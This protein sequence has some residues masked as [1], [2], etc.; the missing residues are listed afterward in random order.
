MRVRKL[1]A[2]LALAFLPAVA[3]AQGMGAQDRGAEN[4]AGPPEFDDARY[5]EDYSF[6]RDPAN[7][8]GAWWERYK[9]IPLD[10]TGTHYLTLGADLRL[11]YEHY[12]NRD[13]GEAPAP[14]DGYGLFRVMPYADLH[15]GSHFRLF[16][17]LIGAWSVDVDP[18]PTPVDETGL[19]VLQAFAQL[20]FARNSRTA[21][22][23]GGRQ[24][25]SYGSE[26]LI[27]MRFGEN[28][29]LAFDGGLARIEDGDWRVDA[30]F[31]Q[32]VENRRDS[33]DDK[34]DS[35]RKLWS[36]YATR[37]L[38]YIG[39][40]SGLDLYYIGFEDEK[41]SYEQGTGEETRHTIGSRFFGTLDNWT[42]DWEGFLQFGSF[43]D[44]DILAWAVGGVTRYTFTDLRLK[45]FIELR[46]NAI[47]GDRDPDD[48]ELNS[49]NA[50]F[51]RAKYFGEIGVLGPRNL[52]N[53]HPIAGVDLG[54]GWSL[55]GATVFFWRE[56]LDDGV[57][58]GPGDLLRASGDS[59]ARYIGTQSELVLGWSAARGVDIQA[60]YSVFKPGSFIEETG[61][62]KTI[63]FF[64]AEVQLRF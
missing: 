58:G 7:W 59:K 53:I 38:P 16:G 46:A 62:S 50:M 33:F 55:S 22:L 51:P 6:L 23:Q 17:Q 64:G 20:R 60:A 30:F 2:T 63:K 28:V 47:S 39:K 13:W 32:P 14:T 36:I 8:T 37:K 21:I 41:A 12:T 4:R 5:G 1:S 31:M 35:T 3:F 40:K 18:A 26:R 19:D 61:P 29:P 10:P 34:T 49:F 48:G 11:E 15:L 24:L 52:L 54:R 25:L 42:W 56:S 9:F 44:D 57:Y 45:P 43:A 27:G